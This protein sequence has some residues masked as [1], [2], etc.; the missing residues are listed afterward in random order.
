MQREF[1]GAVSRWGY[2]A[3][4]WV[5]DAPIGN[6]SDNWHP[7]TASYTAMKT[8]GQYITVMPAMDLVVAHKN[9]NIDQN[10]NRNVTVPQ[11]QTILQ[12][13]AGARR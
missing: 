12:M 4:W 6:T 9:A 1:G 11:Y 5:W 10:P 13:L 2:G 8:D 3:M 7:F